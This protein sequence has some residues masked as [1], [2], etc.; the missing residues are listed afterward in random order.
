M[1]H[2]ETGAQWQVTCPCGWRMHGT[3]EA[4]VNGVR[5]HAR[6]HGHEITEA[7]AMARIVRLND[8]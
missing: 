5:E 6:S 4:V 7:Q 3:K 2:S 1:Q 8:A